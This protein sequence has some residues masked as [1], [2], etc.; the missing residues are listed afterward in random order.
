MDR[1]YCLL[2][3]GVV[4]VHAYYDLQKSDFVDLPDWPK[5]EKEGKP[6]YL[7]LASPDGLDKW[8]VTRDIQCS[9]V[10]PHQNL[11]TGD[12]VT[13]EHLHALAARM[14]CAGTFGREVWLFM[15]GKDPWQAALQASPVERTIW[16]TAAA[17]D[18][19]I[20][21]IEKAGGEIVGQFNHEI[22][23]WCEEE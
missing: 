1:S 2:R 22:M 9:P 10:Y 5:L 4:F 12:E 6:I 11:L 17:P 16:D 8:T 18:Y 19:A 21:L 13:H 7:A 20:G 15:G 14:G 23:F 3:C